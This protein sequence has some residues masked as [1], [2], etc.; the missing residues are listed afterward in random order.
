MGRGGSDARGG[1]SVARD[2]GVCIEAPLRVTVLESIAELRSSDCFVVGNSG[3]RSNTVGRGFLMYGLTGADFDSNA[4][5]GFAVAVWCADGTDSGASAGT[6]VEVAVG[7]GSGLGSV[8]DTRG[9]WGL[10]EGSGAAFFAARGS[11]VKT[12]P[13]REHLKV[14]LSAGRTRSSMR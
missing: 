2:L 6:S 4:G 1:G 10:D 3:A 14:G 13:H 7:V 12:W 11:V 9:V 5:C 8:R